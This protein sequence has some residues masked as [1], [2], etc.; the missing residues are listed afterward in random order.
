MTFWQGL[1]ITILAETTDVG[2][3]GDSTEWAT[4]AQNFLICLEMLL[5]SIAHFYCFPTEEWAEDYKV[6]FEKGRFGDSIAL[7]DFMA[8]LR[9]I[10]KGNTRKKSKK[11]SEPTVPEGDEEQ[12]DEESEAAVDND[13][14][15]STTSDITSD[16]N[17]LEQA[18]QVIARA[19]FCFVSPLRFCV[20]MVLLAWNHESHVVQETAC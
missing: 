17:D 9:L 7:G 13:E 16:T 2:G 12:P 20:P 14:T 4:S 18:K 19:F 11:P 1:A 3:G 15:I 6:N 5:F 10:M 8:D